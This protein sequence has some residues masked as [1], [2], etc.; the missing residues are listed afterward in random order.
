MSFQFNQDAVY[1]LAF[2]NDEIYLVDVRSKFFKKF[3]VTA[4]ASVRAVETL[5]LIA[6]NR[7]FNTVVEKERYVF[8]RGLKFSKSEIENKIAEITSK[9]RKIFISSY[10]L[11]KIK[12]LTKSR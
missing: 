8:E 6:H 1:S 5:F 4:D 10:E 12:S 7:G 9:N 3:D 11:N 2:K